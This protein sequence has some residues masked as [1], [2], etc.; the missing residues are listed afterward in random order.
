M[1]DQLRQ[2]MTISERPATHIVF[3]GMGEPFHNYEQ[4]LRAAEIIHAELGF[5]IGARRITISTSGLIPRIR[6]FADEGRR[7]KLAVSLNATLDKQR[8]AFMPINKKWNIAALVKA[9][10]YYTAKTHTRL[11]F[12]YVL[13][14]G[15]NDAL[16]D[17]RRLAKIGNEMFCKVNVIPYNETGGRFQRPVDEAIEAFLVELNRKAKFPLTVRWSRGADIAAACGQLATSRLNAA[18]Q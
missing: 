5:G 18:V 9:C 2:V 1:A 15:I 10:R 16:A 7:F 4:V 11:T 13:M 3:M 14:A 17:A 6:R 8:T 12:E